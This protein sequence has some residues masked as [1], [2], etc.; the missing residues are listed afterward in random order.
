MNNHMFE[1]Q[2]SKPAPTTRARDK[3][4]VDLDAPGQ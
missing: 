2:M 1:D 3:S 4:K